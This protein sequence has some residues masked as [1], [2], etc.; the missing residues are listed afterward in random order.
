MPGTGDGMGTKDSEMGKGVGVKCYGFSVM[1]K[2]QSLGA[3]LG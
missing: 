2:S 1:V 3:V